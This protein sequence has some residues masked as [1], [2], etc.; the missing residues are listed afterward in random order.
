MN[1]IIF[2]IRNVLKLKSSKIYFV[3]SMGFVCLL[4]IFHLKKMHVQFFRQLQIK[5]KK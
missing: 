5:S 1:L 4:K 3:I 2:K